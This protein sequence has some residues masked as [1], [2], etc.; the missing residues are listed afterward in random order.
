MVPMFGWKY[1]SESIDDLNIF[2]RFQMKTFTILICLS[3]MVIAGCSTPEERAARRAAERER[4][5][6]MFASACISY[7]HE[8]GTPSYNQCVAQEERAYNNER[9][10]AAAEAEAQKAA[11]KA[12][13]VE[14]EARQM[15]SDRDFD[16]II[17]GGVPVGG[18]CL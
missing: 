18:S 17:S 4:L 3:A 9:R 14:R 8:E 16:C 10:I 12:R 6:R 7:G 13:K 2:V 1:Q 11:K 5:E 15:Q